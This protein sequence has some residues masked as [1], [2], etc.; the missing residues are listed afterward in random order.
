M[1]SC[2][3]DKVKISI[4][5]ES[6]GKGIGVVV[7]NLPAGE[8][9]DMD[10]LLLQMGRRA[11]GKDKTATPRLE[12]DL[13]I[14][15]SGMLNDTTTGTPLCAVIENTN[16]RSGDYGNLLTS[17]RPGH[18]DY[19]G[20]VRYGG[21]NDIRGGGHFSGRLTAP[22][23]FAGSVCRQ[24][25]E[26]KGIRIASHIQ[27]I[28]NVCDEKFNPLAVDDKLIDKLNQRSFPVINDSIEDSM[29]DFV[30]QARMLQDSTGGIIECVATGVPAG[31]G[32]PMFGGVENLI[33]SIV[34]GIP[35]VKGIEFGA[36][37]SITEMLGSEAN[38][39]Y[40]YDENGN[41]VTLTNNNGG[42]TGGITNGMPVLFRVAVKPTPSISKPQQTVDLVNH[43]NTTLEI[44]GRH[45]PCIVPRA[46]VVL[47]SA[48]AIAL[49]NL[50]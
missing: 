35:A 29:R 3:G 12:K 16:T 13:P 30:E 14:I 4:F 33:S 26:N 8:K 27:A 6:H 39:Q 38:D 22:L 20:F 44:K 25:L 19:P 36:G 34:F 41:I 5:G 47:E 2:W 10:K 7:D 24:I 32:S 28:G 50:L 18:G 1:S 31:L 45:D 43:T 40:A 46:T 17:P 11:P 49:M 48:L 21:F 42:I 23:V 9:I 37:F 15:M